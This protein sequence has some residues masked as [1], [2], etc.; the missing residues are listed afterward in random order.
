VSGLVNKLV[1][2]LTVEIPHEALES[3]SP[4]SAIVLAEQ[5][6]EQVMAYEAE[7]H[8]GYFAALDYYQ[9]QG[10]IDSDLLNALQGISWLSCSMAQEEI[11]IRLRPVFASIKFESVQSPL[12]SLPVVRPN[13]RNALQNLIEHYTADKVKLTFTASMIRKP[14][15]EETTEAYARHVI[16]KWLRDHFASFEI[17]S[18]KKVD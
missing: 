4:V 16:G 1:V 15:V 2:T 9:Q 7:H 17:K 3:Q 5:L 8:M 6:A 13:S 11:K 14:E 12:N 10:V 18:I